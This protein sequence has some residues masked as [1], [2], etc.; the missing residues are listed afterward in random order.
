MNLCTGRIPLDDAQR[1][2]CSSL[3]QLDN[4]PL[5]AP[6]SQYSGTTSVAEKLNNPSISKLYPI[7][8]NDQYGDCTVA[9]IAHHLTLQNGLVGQTV[10]PSAQ[11]VINLYFKLSGG[12]D[13]GLALSTV[14]QALTKGAFGQNILGDCNVDP[15]SMVSVKKG[16]Q[17]L[18]G[19]FIGFNTTS[20]TV[21]QFQNGQPWTVT[22][23]RE[24]GGH[25]V[26]VTGFDDDKGMFEILTWG[27]LQLATYEWWDKYVDE[28]HAIVTTAL[29]TFD[30][31]TVANI[32]KAMPSLS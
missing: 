3:P 23:Y 12:R 14:L 11:D 32:V 22:N 16:I 26:V 30:N 4:Y 8:G 20:Q 25:A 5:P 31:E 28:A 7:N 27:G 18:K 6:A 21:P 15:S 24:Q 17:Y 1:A 9:G 2:Y 29:S 10:I 19:L 13:S